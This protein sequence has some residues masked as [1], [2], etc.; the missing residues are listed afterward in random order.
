M[1]RQVSSVVRR[2]IRFMMRSDL[3]W[4]ADRQLHEICCRQ[5]HSIMRKRAR[6]EFASH[7]E[8]GEILSG[9]FKGMKYA[10]EA[11]VGSSL[12]PK[13]LGTYESELQP[14]IA[15]IT[16]ADYQK[17][18]DVGFAEGY[19]LV[20]FGRLFQQAELIGFDC[21]SEAQRL[22]KANAEI[23][24]IEDDRLK[25]FGAFD[26]EQ[27]QQ[28][29]GDEKTLVVVDCEGT[30][31]D[32]I[33]GLDREQLLA[34]DW[35]IETHDH[36][37]E[38]TTKRLLKV[39]EETHVLQEVVT[40]DDHETKC[41]LLPDSIKQSCDVLRARGT[42]FRRT[43]IATILDFCQTQGSLKS[44]FLDEQVDNWHPLCP[45]KAGWQQQD[46]ALH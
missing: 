46:I 41:R 8:R 37:V 43:Q 6:R 1:K 22:C 42:R 4:E 14:F 12:W 21:E 32:V 13:L 5:R 44:V 10:E 35:L 34:A 28:S 25:L 31:N 11:A 33:D 30:E 23:N 27:F 39:F 15:E 26:C 7:I 3:L 18:I 40:D 38:G 16:R 20:G 29:L 9:P 19:Y 24:G 17:I 36:L 2:V 45:G